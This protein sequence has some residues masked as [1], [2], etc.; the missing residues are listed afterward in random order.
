MRKFCENSLPWIGPKLLPIPNGLLFKEI[1]THF[2]GSRRFSLNMP[3]SFPALFSVLI[4]GNFPYF[5]MNS[6]M[7]WFEKKS[8]IFD[9]S[10]LHFWDFRGCVPKYLVNHFSR[11][12]SLDSQFNN[13]YPHC[14]HL[15][16]YK[17]LISPISPVFSTQHCD[18][19][20]QMQ[21][22]IN[23][24]SNHIFLKMQLDF[25]CL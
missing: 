16:D 1:V 15:H 20:N 18:L 19:T 17:I 2:Q 23:H 10:F 7:Y 21:A 8:I 11:D 14:S 4:P 6:A 13:L 12:R 5:S 25:Y 9:P 3:F 22:F 24:C